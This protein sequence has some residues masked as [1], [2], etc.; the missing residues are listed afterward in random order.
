[1]KVKNIKYKTREFRKNEV[2]VLNS[3]LAELGVDRFV[4]KSTRDKIDDYIENGVGFYERIHYNEINRTFE[5]IF[6]N[7]LSIASKINL[8]Y[9]PN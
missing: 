3:K 1:M 8:L 2:D 6:N 4:E 9:K 5:Y 7:K